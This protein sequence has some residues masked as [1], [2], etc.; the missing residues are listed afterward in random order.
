MLSTLQ[1]LIVVPCHFLLCILARKAQNQVYAR[2]SNFVLKAHVT[3]IHRNVG[4]IFMRRFMRKEESPYFRGKTDSML[5]HAEDDGASFNVIL[6]ESPI[7][8]PREGAVKYTVHRN[9]LLDGRWCPC[10]FD[11]PGL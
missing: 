2:T 5:A 9:N 1:T 4:T 6:M 10:Y 7:Q 3:L 8:S 11:L